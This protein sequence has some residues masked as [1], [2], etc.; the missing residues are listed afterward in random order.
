MGTLLEDWSHL[1][2]PSLQGQSHGLW[3]YLPCSTAW[4]YVGMKCIFGD[5]NHSPFSTPFY[6]V[7]YLPKISCVTGATYEM[8]EVLRKAS[9]GLRFLPFA[10]V[11]MSYGPVW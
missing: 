9:A 10:I 5:C 3:T 2:Y 6:E 4:Y 1:E 11:T 7:I 8:I